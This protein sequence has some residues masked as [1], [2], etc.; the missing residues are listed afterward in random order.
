MPPEHLAKA[1]TLSNIYIKHTILRIFGE[2]SPIS[3]TIVRSN[4]IY[5][6]APAEIFVRGGGKP[7]KKAPHVH[8]K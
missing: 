1:G 6:W 8:K 5:S 4:T 2:A 3:L 7:K